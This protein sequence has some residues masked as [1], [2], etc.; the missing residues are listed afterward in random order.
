MPVV[1]KERENRR[2]KKQERNLIPTGP[3]KIAILS[4]SQGMRN[5]GIHKAFECPVWKTHTLISHHPR[6]PLSAWNISMDWG[7][8]RKDYLKTQ[9]TKINERCHAFWVCRKLVTQ[10]EEKLFIQSTSHTN[11]LENITLKHSKLHLHLSYRETHTLSTQSATNRETLKKKT[12]HTFFIEWGPKA[13]DNID[14][15]EFKIR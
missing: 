9:R 2:R 12:S 15:L 5:G 1:L 14:N 6:V 7:K 11:V 8:F 3:A 13:W 4:L 10:L